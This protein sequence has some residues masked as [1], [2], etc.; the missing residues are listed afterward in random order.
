MVSTSRVS[1]VKYVF[2]FG[3]APLAVQFVALVRG[4]TGDFYWLFVTLSAMAA[5]AFVVGLLLP[6]AGRAAR[7]TPAPAAAE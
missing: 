7:S 6:S 1:G 5:V 4:N 3:S 2:A